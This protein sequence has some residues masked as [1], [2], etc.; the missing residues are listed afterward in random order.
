MEY[1]TTARPTV[2]ADSPLARPAGRRPTQTQ[3]RLGSSVGGE[4]SSSGDDRRAGLI[5]QLFAQHPCWRDVPPA[6]DSCPEARPA[7]HPRHRSPAAEQPPGTPSATA[8]PPRS[9]EHGRRR[10]IVRPRRFLSLHLDTPP[11]LRR[12]G[13]AAATGRLTA[14]WCALR[15]PRSVTVDMSPSCQVHAYGTSLITPLITP[16]IIII[17]TS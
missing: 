4:G 5:E 7:P 1:C 12:E 13:P 3:R 9:M 11:T 17:M 10:P 6:G 16:P 14:A 2:G 8:S 15:S